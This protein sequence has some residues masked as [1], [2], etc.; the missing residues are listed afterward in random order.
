MALPDAQAQPTTALEGTRQGIAAAQEETRKYSFDDAERDALEEVRAKF[1]SVRETIYPQR[2]TK[3]GSAVDE[4]CVTAIETA[5]KWELA[6][7]ALNE[8][9]RENQ[10]L[11]AEIARLE[12]EARI[13]SREMHSLLKGDVRR[14]RREVKEEVRRE[15]AARFDSMGSRLA[16]AARDGDAA[17]A[18]A[19]S[20]RARVHELETSA[21]SEQRARENDAR[22]EREAWRASS[23]AISADLVAAR[24]LAEAEARAHADEKQRAEK[25]RAELACAHA[26]LANRP[27][28]GAAAIAAE[29]KTTPHARRPDESDSASTTK[30]EQ[31]AKDDH[32]DEGYSP[33]APETL[34]PNQPVGKAKTSRVTPPSP[35]P[36]AAP[37]KAWSPALL[38]APATPNEVLTP[39]PAASGADE[40]KTE[41]VSIATK[42]VA[43]PASALPQ[44]AAPASPP[45]DD[46]DVG[47]G[48][49]GVMDQ[50]ETPAETRG[51]AAL[52]PTANDCGLGDAEVPVDA[53][54]PQEPQIELL[55]PEKLAALPKT[56]GGDFGLLP[57]SSP[58]VAREHPR[59]DATRMAF[60]LIDC[61]RR[62]RG[63]L[64]RAVRGASQLKGRFRAGTG[65]GSVNE[66]DAAIEAPILTQEDQMELVKNKAA[67]A[68]EAEDYKGPALDA[69]LRL[70]DQRGDPPEAT[71]PQKWV[72]MCLGQGER[73]AVRNARDFEIGVPIVREHA[74]QISVS[75][76]RRADEGRLLKR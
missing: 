27:R 50:P 14:I 72:N 21:V 17:L 74:R 75:G 22:S 19:A 26:E 23:E 44:Q 63:H 51:L 16:I 12:E 31:L 8:K 1:N 24:R 71:D 34:T 73:A 7:C 53:V 64:K 37:P 4:V 35:D 15:Y 36:A 6:G 2:N 29:L 38:E 39:A 13:G 49:V 54:S 33:V 76:K 42:N 59:D 10:R 55:V 69:M 56:D 43:A 40:Q 18:D 30:A 3:S 45:A 67:R 5:D 11:R 58:P 68:L 32:R 9:T 61:G 28:E 47:G 46:G 48:D 70:T 57:P 20:A 66:A 41:A 60:N 25:L 62:P 52:A 65:E